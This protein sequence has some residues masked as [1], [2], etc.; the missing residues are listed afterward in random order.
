VARARFFTFLEETLKGDAADESEEEMSDLEDALAHRAALEAEIERLQSEVKAMREM[1]GEI[2]RQH[3]AEIE[4]L[5]A[6][7]EELREEITR[8]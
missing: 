4:R 6:V 7:I 3:A 5:R 8:K 1:V 2:D